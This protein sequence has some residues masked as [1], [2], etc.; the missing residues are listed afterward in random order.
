VVQH[1]AAALKKADERKPVEGSYNPGIGPHPEEEAI[2]LALK[3]HE[4]TK[5]PSQDATARRLRARIRPAE[6]NVT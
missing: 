3:E 6:E 4:N 1:F 5:S 2:D